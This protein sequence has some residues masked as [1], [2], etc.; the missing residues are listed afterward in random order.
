MRVLLVNKY[1]H[2]TGGADTY[3]I[4]VK[5]LLKK[6]GHLTAEFC[7]EDEGN[8]P[9]AFQEYFVFGLTSKTWRRA[10]ICN[11]AK[12]LINSLYNF[13]ALRKFRSLVEQFKP[14]VVHIHNI[15]YQISPSFLKVTKER[16]IPVVGTLHDYHPVCANNNLY[17]H[18]K[19]CKDCFSRSLLYIIRNRCYNES[20]K[21]SILA[22]LSFSFR[23][24]SKT[25]EPLVDIWISPSRFLYD[26]IAARGFNKNKLRLLPYMIEPNREEILNRKEDEGY[27]LFS[28]RYET[29]KGVMTL[30]KAAE[31][32]KNIKF[33]LAGRGPYETN[34]KN[35]I[36]IKELHNVEV[37]SFLCRAEL[38][39][40]IKRA[41]IIVVPSEWYENYPYS[42]LEAMTLGKA[43]VASSIGG[44]PELIHD[45]HSGLLFEAGNVKD[46]IRK[47]SDLY[48]DCEKRILFGLNAI[49]QVMSINDPE[50]HYEQ[51]L[52]IYCE[53]IKLKTNNK[54]GML[55]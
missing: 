35:Y 34:I 10:S 49:E 32:L 39:A 19:L 1:N 48:F 40:L 16:N 53:A 55:I 51:L 13:E 47:L 44:I 15:F 41:R 26:T 31:N 36:C 23:K 6:K 33:I 27:V 4:S 9:S 7:M 42:I 46:L 50:S 24:M 12:A 38:K 11:S 20:L 25:Y 43:V 8:M 5:E 3:F 14:E 37:K 17:H 30:L 28:G 45:G 29:H 18:G 21:A 2:I 22:Y 52:R 54:A